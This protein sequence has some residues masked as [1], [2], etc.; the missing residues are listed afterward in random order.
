MPDEPVMVCGDGQLDDGERCDTAIAEGELGAC[1]TS[2]SAPNPC[3]PQAL[4]GSD[5]DARCEPVTPECTDDD[6]CCPEGCSS[7][8]DNDCSGSCG[9]GVVQEELGETC[10]VPDPDGDAQQPCVTECPDD[11]DACTVEALVG[12]AD[13]CNAA[14]TATVIDVA[15]AGDGCCPEGGDN[16]VDEDCPIVCGNGAV[17]QGEECDGG[18]GCEDCELLPTPEEL[19][20]Q[21]ALAGTGDDC[22]ECTCR[23]CTAATNDCF[24]SGDATRDANCAMIVLCGIENDCLGSQCYCGLDVEPNGTCL[25]G[26]GPCA[27][28]LD[29][30]AA[31]PG[32]LAVYTEQSDPTTAIGRASLFSQCHQLTGCD[33]ECP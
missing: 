20:C 32:A 13:N 11:G 26:D 27:A 17:E 28:V 2:C 18:E 30:A 29:A 14:C 33:L 1:P 10:E 8:T 4:R 16:N 3:L 22:R 21:D 31:T 7:S 12:S 23:D 5:C 15:A 9:D 24:D 6:A 19:L 25:V